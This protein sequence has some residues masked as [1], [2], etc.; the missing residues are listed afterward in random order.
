[1]D[2]IAIKIFLRLLYVIPI[3]KKIKQL[4]I[5]TNDKIQKRMK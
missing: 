1:M 4:T 3:V 2:E 5:I